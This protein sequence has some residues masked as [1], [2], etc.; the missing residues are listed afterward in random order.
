MATYEVDGTE[1][2]FPDDMTDEEVQR[3]LEDN[4]VIQRPQA[5]QEPRGPVTLGDAAKAALQYHGKEAAQALGAAAQGAAFGIPGWLEGKLFGTRELQKAESRNPVISTVAGFAAPNPAAKLKGA[6]G[7][8]GRIASGAASGAVGAGTRGGDPLLGGIIGGGLAS[9]G[10]IGSG[11]ARLRSETLRDKAG[12]RAAKAMGPMLK[13]ARAMSRYDEVDDMGREIIETGRQMLD[14][15][16]LDDPIPSKA[17]IAARA[18]ES[19]SKHGREISEGVR[20]LDEAAERAGTPWSPG[21][22]ADKIHENVVAPIADIPHAQAGLSGPRQAIDFLDRWER[23]PTKAELLKIRPEDIHGELAEWL[24][25]PDPSKGLV[26]RPRTFSQARDYRESMDKFINWATESE[27]SDA[28]RKGVRRQLAGDIYGP[29]GQGAQVSAELA[30]KIRDAN[31]LFSRAK[32]VSDVASDRV[33]RDFANRMV[34]PSSYGAGAASAAGAAASGASGA[35]STI[36]GAASAIV[37]Q[38][39]LHFGNAWSAKALD[40]MADLSVAVQGNPQLASLITEAGNRG[41]NAT[42]A[43]LRSMGVFDE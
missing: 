13:D 27:G 26:T 35:E 23:S 24:A 37:N 34:S 1:Y 43:L 31:R 10:E 30:A 41:P 12:E 8:A 5:A 9:A 42:L 6:A 36:K 7:V 29:S 15:G 40:K 16:M 22:T 21:R 39:L 20:A 14:E 19:A 2:E 17:K 38:V 25:N 18:S 32:T 28:L 11:I 3:A 33:S 4:G